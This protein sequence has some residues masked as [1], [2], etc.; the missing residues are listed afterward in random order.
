MFETKFVNNIKLIKNILVIPESLVESI[1]IWYHDNLNHHGI[2]RTFETINMHF[3]CKDLKSIVYEYMLSCPVCAKQKKSNK[4]YGHLPPSGPIYRP[5]EY[6]HIDLFGPWS[7]GCEA[8]KLHQIR[9]V[10][11][12][13]SS[14]YWIELYEY[15][16][17]SSRDI[18][19]VFDDEWLCR[20]SFTRMVVFDNGT[21]FSSEFHEIPQRY[22]M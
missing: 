10:S 8:G 4:K 1:V 21:D 18:C 2:N 7:I 16:S 20:Y 17:K 11:I 22:G 15:D 19:F 12:I 3:T 13:D 6:V 14:F 5:W 9:V